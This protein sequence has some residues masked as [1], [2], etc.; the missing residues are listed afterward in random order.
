MPINISVLY[1]FAGYNFDYFGFEIISK[2]SSV[3]LLE[4]VVSNPAGLVYL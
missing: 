1:Q 4:L 2:N 3:C